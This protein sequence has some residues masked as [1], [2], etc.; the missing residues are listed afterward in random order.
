MT[1]RI[2]VLA[3]AAAAAIVLGGATAAAAAAA[4]PAAR[5]VVYHGCESGQH[6]RVIYDVYA[7]GHQPRCPRGAWPIAWNARGPQ[8]ARGPRGPQG[9]AGTAAAAGPVAEVDNGAEFAVSGS[10][11]LADTSAKGATYADAGSVTSAGTVGHLNAAALAFTGTGPLA[12]NIWIG[13][14]PQASVPGIYPLK[15]GADFCYGLGTQVTSGQPAAFQMQSGCGTY[16][17]AT[18]TIAQ[19]AADFPAGLQA[20][21]WVGVVSSGSAVPAA[22]ITSI[23]GR[24]VSLTAGVLASG[25]V[26]TPYTSP[27]S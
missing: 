8:G 20:Y 19:I 7:D 14:G 3:T 24:K 17:G 16:A 23:G 21:A 10:P 2:Q 4:A 22:T 18:L 25:G 12:E 11:V 6:G 9:P 5:P 1:R 15:G 13:D 27:A 26:L